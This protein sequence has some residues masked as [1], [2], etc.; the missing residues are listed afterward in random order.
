M[1]LYTKMVKNPKYTSNKKNG[2]KIPE[3]KDK[4]VLYVPIGCGECIECRR[5]KTREWK[6][7]LM[8]EMKNDKTGQYV[9]L[10]FSEESLEKLE[11]EH[12]TKE[13]NE[14]AKIAVK[15]FRERWRKKYKKSIK[16]WLIPELG[17]ENTERLH[18]HGILYTDKTTEEIEERWGYGV[19][20]VGYSMNMRCIN[21]IVKYITKVDKDHPGFK[22]KILTSPGIGRGYADRLNAKRNKYNG[23]ETDELYRM[24]NGAKTAL[25]IYYRNKIYTE[26]ERE[27]LWIHKIEEDTMYVNGKKIENVSSKKG[28]ERLKKAI[29]RAR[30][31][32]KRL[33]YGDGN[34]KNKEYY[35]K[36]EVKNLEDTKKDA[37]FEKFLEDTNKLIQK[38]NGR[39]NQKNDGSR[40]NHER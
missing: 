29:I 19:I 24:E 40:K 32:N 14:V 7:R 8:E 4:R 30:K 11:N 16:H 15:L 23:K 3:C 21:Y 18:L 39:K 35:A 1:C 28:E 37:I 17:H 25:P 6:V 38:Q 9:T 22:G 26:E 33:G 2:G 27:K 12:K 20:T 36:K 10:T 34:R 5:K 13:A 31:E